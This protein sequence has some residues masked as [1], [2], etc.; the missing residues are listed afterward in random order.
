MKNKYWTLRQINFPADFTSYTLPRQPE[1]PRE[2]TIILETA[3]CSCTTACQS[4]FLLCLTHVTSGE[5][6]PFPNWCGQCATTTKTSHQPRCTL[7]IHLLKNLYKL[8]DCGDLIC[9]L[10]GPALHFRPE[11]GS[12]ED[13][14]F[15]CTSRCPCKKL[16]L[17]SAV[18][19]PE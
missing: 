9:W 15:L 3:F 5:R 1:W 11:P 12:Q 18:P 7:V 2:N 8:S 6:W 14:I 4:C 17:M 13:W 19:L 16:T 10:H